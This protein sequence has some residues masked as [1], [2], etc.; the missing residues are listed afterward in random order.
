VV[1][2]QEQAEAAADGERHGLVAEFIE[3]VQ[4]T[5]P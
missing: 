5:G 4:Q 2:L 1:S 3:Q